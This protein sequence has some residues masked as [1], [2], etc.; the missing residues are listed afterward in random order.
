MTAS[1][2]F[3]WSDSYSGENDIQDSQHRR[4]LALCSRPSVLMSDENALASRESF[5]NSSTKCHN[6]PMNTVKTEEAI[7]EK[8]WISSEAQLSTPPFCGRIAFYLYV[9]VR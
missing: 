4:L 8:C 5:M 6:F 2:D 1:L 3:N 9:C 7:L